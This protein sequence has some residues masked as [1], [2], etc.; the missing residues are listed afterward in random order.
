MTEAGARMGGR[1]CV[2][3]QGQALSGW[4]SPDPTVPGRESSPLENENHSPVLLP[5]PLQSQPPLSCE[6]LLL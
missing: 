5:C 2:S 3:S 6:A 4:H 1:Q